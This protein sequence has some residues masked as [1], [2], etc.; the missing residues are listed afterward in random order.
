MDP[1]ASV[2]LIVVLIGAIVAGYYIMRP[3]TPQKN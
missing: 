3:E 2:G 1:L